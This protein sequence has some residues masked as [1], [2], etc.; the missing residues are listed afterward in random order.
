M[1]SQSEALARLDQATTASITN[2]PVGLTTIPADA[3]RR[4]V[5]V[6]CTSGTCYVQFGGNGSD[7]SSSNYASKLSEADVY[8]LMMYSGV[9][10]VRCD[11]ESSAK[12]T[13]LG[14]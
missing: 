7:L 12:V 3:N 13:S 14:D 5:I 6:T 10:H 8:E 4:G 11:L 9:V 1:P 2:C